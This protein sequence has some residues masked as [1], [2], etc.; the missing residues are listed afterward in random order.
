ME[1]SLTPKSSCDKT[2]NISKRQYQKKA[3]KT[4][5]HIGF[6]MLPIIGMTPFHASYDI[7]RF[8]DDGKKIHDKIYRLKLPMYLLT[9]LERAKELVEDTS[10]TLS[11]GWM[12]DIYSLTRQ[13][14]PVSYNPDLRRYVQPITDYITYAISML[15]ESDIEMADQHQPHILK[16][17]LSDKHTG[18]RIHRDR[19][20]I[21]ANLMMSKKDD[22]EGG[23]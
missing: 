10:K 6:P 2:I 22:Y 9:L 14:I 21:T 7:T 15:Y 17:S 13:D 12:T 23:G 11:N 1:K 18:V 19:C 20:D 5:S 4:G 16:Y 3:K 8:S